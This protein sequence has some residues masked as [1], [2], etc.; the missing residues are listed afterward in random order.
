MKRCSTSLLIRKMQIKTSYHF[1][2]TKITIMK[3]SDNNRCWQG[4]GIIGTLVHC[5]QEQ[6]ILQPLWKAVWQFIKGLSIQLL[7]DPAM[8]RLGSKRNKNKC[9]NKNLD[10]NVH[11]SKNNSPQLETTKMSIKG[12]MSKENVVSPYN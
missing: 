9:S 2:P 1:I 6:K 3:K 5:W 7:Y 12:L 10:I 4:C 8:L 11:S